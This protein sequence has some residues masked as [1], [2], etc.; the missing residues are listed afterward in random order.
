[1]SHAKMSWLSAFMFKLVHLVDTF[2]TEHFQFKQ[3]H[4]LCRSSCI[5]LHHIITCFLV[6][7]LRQCLQK[8]NDCFRLFNS[9]FLRMSSCQ[10]AQHFYFLIQYH[11]IKYC[12]YFSCYTYS[13]KLH[14]MT[15]TYETH[16]ECSSVWFLHKS[17]LMWAI[18]LNWMQQFMNCF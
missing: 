7:R 8:M 10:P 18:S 16:A 13:S 11:F 6:E 12:E 17:I 15:L 4:V 3:L 9:R 2:I 14:R 1:M 5:Y